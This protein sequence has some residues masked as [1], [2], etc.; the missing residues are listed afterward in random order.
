MHV[1]RQNLERGSPNL[2]LSASLTV[3]SS[4]F[5]CSLF[6]PRPQPHLPNQ[7]HTARSPLSATVLNR[8]RFIYDFPTPAFLDLFP[9]LSTPNPPSPLHSRRRRLTSRLSWTHL[10]I[11]S[12]RL[13][14]T[15]R[16]NRRR[17]IDSRISN[18]R[19]RFT[20]QSPNKGTPPPH[21]SR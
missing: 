12:R 5:S 3:K 16:P 10:P 17:T 6:A 7:L 20:L 8:Y 19:R 1:L 9:R 15:R 13:P 21:A 18:Y 11:R 2:A 14:M 4:P